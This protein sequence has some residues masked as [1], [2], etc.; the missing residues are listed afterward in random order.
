VSTGALLSAIC[1]RRSFLSGLR[2]VLGYQVLL[3]LQKKETPGWY[4]GILPPI[5]P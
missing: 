2:G 4:K 1:A 5:L 3:S